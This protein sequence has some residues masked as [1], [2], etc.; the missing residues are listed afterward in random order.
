MAAC[1]VSDRRNSNLRW[2]ALSW[3]GGSVVRDCGDLLLVFHS[4]L[5]LR[6]FSVNEDLAP[7]TDL[8]LTAVES[9]TE[10]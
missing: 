1:L 4:S 6:V 7:S 8:D 10:T 9:H 3:C 2:L 5:V